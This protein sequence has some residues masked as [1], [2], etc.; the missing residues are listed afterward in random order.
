MSSETPRLS[1]PR[2]LVLNALWFGSSFQSAALLPVVIPA[3]VLLMIAPGQLGSSDQAVYLGRLGAAA[4]LVA[5]I[6][7]PLV[8]R[9]SDRLPTRLGRRRPW[10]LAGTIA[11]IGA[12]LLLVVLRSPIWYALAFL[13]LQLGQSLAVAAYQALLPDI[14]PRSQRGLASGYLGVMQIL[15]YAASLGLAMLLLGSVTGADRGAI[16]SGASRYLIASVAV[17]AVFGLITILGVRERGG[18]PPPAP[19]PL[20]RQLTSFLEPWRHRNYSWVFAARTLVMCGFQLFLAFIEYYFARVVHATDFVAATAQVA[21]VALAVAVVGAVVLGLISD[22]TRR[23]PLALAATVV[24]A[25]AAGLFLVPGAGRWL[26]LLGGL[27]GLGYGAY[28]SVDWALAVDA[29]P[30]SGAAGQD[31]GLFSL[32]STL[33]GLVAPALGSVVIAAFA[34]AGDTNLGYRAVFAVALLFFLAGAGAVLGIRESPRL[35]SPP[36]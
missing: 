14:V 2:L 3:Q 35:P 31:L 11:A 5:M 15:G 27:F 10:I 13:G 28:M 19:V 1:T 29:L 36:A 7:Q 30:S 22:R 23:V 26:W 32:A 20:R 16:V 21:L 25:L 6:S 24:M 8:G 4:A 12:T 9:L 34:A 33:P 17:V 18:V